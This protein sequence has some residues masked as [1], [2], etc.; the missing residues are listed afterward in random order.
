MVPTW[1]GTQRLARLVGSGMAKE[2]LLSGDRFSVEEAH[3]MGLINKIVP[4][5][6]LIP[7]CRDLARRIMANAPLAVL[8]TKLAI[9]E[10][11]QMPLDQALHYETELWLANF[12]TED[13]EE[14][15]R[16]FIEKRKANFKGR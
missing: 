5:E 1:G 11:L 4:H 12:Y 7:Y 13:R 9:N 8:R 3:R 14:G 15:T 16:S 2:I 6:N 10:G